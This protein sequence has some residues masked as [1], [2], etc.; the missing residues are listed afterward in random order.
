MDMGAGVW[1][2]LGTLIGPRF[3]SLEAEVGYG[4]CMQFLKFR[5]TVP[6]HQESS[7]LE[8]LDLGGGQIYIAR[9][10]TALLQGEAAPARDATRRHRRGRRCRGPQGV[11]IVNGKFRNVW[12]HVELKPLVVSMGN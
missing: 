6:G 11:R 3:E 2:W 12:T 9:I 10:V 8:A 4:G 1:N 7:V 5:V